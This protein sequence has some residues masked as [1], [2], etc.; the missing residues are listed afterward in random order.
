VSYN[1][2]VSAELTR[3]I[4]HFAIC[5]N[6]LA[7]AEIEHLIKIGIG[8]H[9]GGLQEETKALNR[10]HSIYGDEEQLEEGCADIEVSGF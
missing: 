9:L 10:F 3:L 5:E 7:E 2:T 4:E 1:I 6:R 8:V